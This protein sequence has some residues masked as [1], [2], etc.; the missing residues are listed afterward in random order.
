M[1]LWQGYF[2][3]VRELP[4]RHKGEICVCSWNQICRELVMED[5]ESEQN[6]ILISSVGTGFI[7]SWKVT[8]FE[9]AFSRPGKVMDFRKNGRGCGKVME[10]HF[11]VQIF[12]AVWKFEHSP[13]HRAEM[14][15]KRPRFRHLLVMENL[16]WS[17]KSHGKVIEF[18]CQISVWTLRKYPCCLWIDICYEK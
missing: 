14:C 12:C 10:F 11:L 4:Y 9:N 1:Y 5:V 7:R 2:D 13:C 3:F 15:P 6:Q 18:Y 8:E 17:W 16:N